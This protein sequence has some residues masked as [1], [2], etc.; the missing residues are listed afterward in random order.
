VYIAVF[1]NGTR[2]G[3]RE[4][5]IT[6]SCVIQSANTDSPSWQSFGTS[7]ST[8]ST[9]WKPAM[10]EARNH[11]LLTTRKFLHLLVTHR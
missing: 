8:L 3:T 4:T 11:P 1:K 10:P 6:I 2:G 7:A 9:P 5:T